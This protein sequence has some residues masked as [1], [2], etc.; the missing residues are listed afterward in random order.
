MSELTL[1]G[2]CGS[3][4]ADSYNRKLMHAAAKSFGP[5]SFVEGDLN[6]PLFNEDVEAQGMPDAVTRLKEQV[7]AADAVVIACP[8]YNKAPPGAL[9]NALDWLSRGG[10][11]WTDKP[12]A[13]VSATAGRAG[14]ERTQFALRLM[15]VAFRPH[16]LMGPEVL[17]ASP[18]DHF[19]DSGS[20]VTESYQNLLDDLMG[21][22]RAAADA[23]R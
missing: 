9:K 17:V 13:L 4:R 8:E 14:G 15:M 19:D 1:L 7:K 16:L 2:L 12:V 23:N 6:L 5:S 20:L 22:L 21:A 10:Q 18:K 11:P 3:L